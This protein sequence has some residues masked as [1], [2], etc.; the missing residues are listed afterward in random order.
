[1]VRKVKRKKLDANFDDLGDIAPEDQFARHFNTGSNCGNDRTTSEIHLPCLKSITY[2]GPNKT[3][4][5]STTQIA[6]NLKKVLYK[7]LNYT[8]QRQKLP[9]FSDL[10]KEILTI[11][12]HYCDFY[13]PCQDLNNTNALRIPMVAHLLNHTLKAR[14]LILKNNSTLKKKKNQDEQDNIAERLGDNDEQNYKDDKLRDQGFTKARILILT[15]FRDGALKFVNIMSDLLFGEST[16]NFVMNR[17]KFESEYG[18]DAGEEDAEETAAKPRFERTPDFEQLFKG[19]TDDCFRIGVSVSKKAL[20]LYVDVK[21]CDIVIASPL[22]LRTQMGSDDEKNFDADFLS[23]IEILVLDMTDIFLMQNW[24]HVLHIFEHLNKKPA[25]ITSITADLYRIRR[26]VLEEKMQL[27]RQT[28]LFSRFD[29][30]EFRGI[31]SKWCKNYEGLTV[32]SFFDFYSNAAAILKVQAAIPQAFHRFD[33]SSLQSDADARFEFFAHKILPDF[34]A[35][36]LKRILIFV[37][38][39]FDFVRVRNLLKSE[40][41]SADM[42]CVQIFEYAEDKKVNRA[43]DLF[44]HAKK[45]CALFTERFHFFKRYHIRGVRHIIFYQL[46][47]YAQFYSEICNW[48]KWSSVDESKLRDEDDENNV[49]NRPTC[50]ILYSKYD[51]YRLANVLGKDRVPVLLN[52]DKKVYLV[53]PII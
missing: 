11:L 29:V 25:K 34:K 18:Y 36:P 13:L 19:N 27:Y 4:T 21:F 10:Q 20:K 7:N 28:I 52:S 6:S 14:S 8:N 22:G 16:K 17:K 35:S 50:T 39:Y 33:S 47:F 12:N 37:P 5:I 41:Y 43:R 1:M 40:E 31:F 24:D 53:E 49:Q 42:P 2:N 45:R 46:P 26:W 38:S 32:G 48:T 30:P 9:E 23:S 3:F 15:P 44:Y 51:S